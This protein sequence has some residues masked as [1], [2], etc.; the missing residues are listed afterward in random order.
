M[1]LAREAGHKIEMNDIANEPFLPA[2][3]FNGSVE[4]FYTEME[5]QEPHFKK[6]YEAAAP[7][8]LS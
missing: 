5:K 1:I 3:C 6:L 8:M 2:S 4:D 7:K